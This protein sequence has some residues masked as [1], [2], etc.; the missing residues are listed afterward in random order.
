MEDQISKGYT[1][2]KS[3]DFELAPSYRD[4]ARKRRQSEMR[5]RFLGLQLR[6]RDLEH[7]LELVKN[8]LISLDKQMQSYAA[9]EQLSIRK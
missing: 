2:Q 7:E 3:N 9:Y 8:C 1:S 6:R 4:D 5:R